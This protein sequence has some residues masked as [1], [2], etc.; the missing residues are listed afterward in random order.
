MKKIYK[1]FK[2]KKIFVN[3]VTAE[4]IKYLSNS[5][6]ANMISFSNDMAM[7]AEKIKNIDI[8]EF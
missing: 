4:F 5:M 1:N 8:K 2:D 3:N 6:L 7:L